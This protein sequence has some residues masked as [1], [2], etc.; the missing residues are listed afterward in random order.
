VKRLPVP[1]SPNA[2]TRLWSTTSAAERARRYRRAE[3]ASSTSR[4]AVAAERRSKNTALRRSPRRSWSVA[5]SERHGHRPV[6]P[7]TV[8][9][10]PSNRMINIDR[11]LP[12]ATLRAGSRARSFRGCPRD[13]WSCVTTSNLEVDPGRRSMNGPRVCR[14]PLCTMPSN[15]SPPASGRAFFNADPVKGHWT[16]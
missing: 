2:C 10:A 15:A 7:S 8:A 6:A 16:P 13:D 14:S 3:P 1:L 9:C 11:V 4:G 12:R 5:S